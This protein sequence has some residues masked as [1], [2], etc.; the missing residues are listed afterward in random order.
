MLKNRVFYGILLLSTAGI[1]IFT[2]TYYTL[3][4]FLLCFILPAISFALMFFS[5]NGLDIQLELPSMAEKGNAVLTYKWQ[6]SSRLPVARVGLVVELENQMTGTHYQRIINATVGGK[7]STCAKLSLQNSKV[8]CIQVST[9]KICVYDIFGIFTLKKSDLKEQT[10]VIYPN[11]QDV[12][13]SME[14]PVETQGDGQ[15]Y[16]ADRPGQDVS[17]IFQ[18]REYVP[19]DEVRKI[20]WKLSSKI[21]RMMVRDFSLPLNYSVFLLMELSEASEEIIDKQIELYLSL[22]KALLENGINHNLAWYDSGEENFIVR[23]LDDFENLEMAM[24][25]VLSSYP[26]EKQ[27][28]ALE[29]YLTSAHRNQRSVL[30]YVTSNPDLSKIKEAEMNQRV[31]TILVYEKGE[32]KT[33]AEQVMDIIP[34][35][36]NSRFPE[37]TV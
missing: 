17:E 30:L 19:G 28:V 23:A 27:A 33:V 32:V 21:D 10:V 3:T 5:R 4:L 12:S 34:A 13:V 24:A 14:K 29:Y 37:I 2:N 31:R 15:R 9:K 7:K 25:E 35:N 20:H 8:G 18:L 6:N 1:Y 36:V 26:S 22:S 11:L 16:A